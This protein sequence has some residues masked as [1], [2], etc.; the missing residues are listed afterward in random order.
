MGQGAKVKVSIHATRCRV[1][2][3]RH[4]S[5]ETLAEQGFNP[6]HPLPGGEATILAGSSADMTVSIHATRC[7]VAKRKLSPSII[8]TNQVSIHATR[9]RVAKPSTKA[10]FCSEELFQSTPPVAG[11]RSPVLARRQARRQCFN[12]RHPLPGGEA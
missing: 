6:R 8:V 11:W 3:R 4:T 12:P 9:C 5:S 10:R 2:K 7:R 1:A